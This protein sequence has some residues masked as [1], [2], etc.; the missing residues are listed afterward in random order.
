MQIKFLVFSRFD[1]RPGFLWSNYMAK[2]ILFLTEIYSS[3]QELC[4][5][6]AP[7]VRLPPAEL[8][9]KLT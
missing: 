8:K 1:K 7:V 6:T 2:P 4:L 3:P 9:A 5:N